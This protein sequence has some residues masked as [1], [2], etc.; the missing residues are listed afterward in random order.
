MIVC[1]AGRADGPRTDGYMIDFFGTARAAAERMG[2]T[3]RI[4]E[5]GYRVE[6]IDY[7]DA[8]GRT[9]ARLG[10]EGFSRLLYRTTIVG[11]SDGRVTVGRRTVGKHYCRVAVSRA[12]LST[13]RAVRGRR[14]QSCS[15]SSVEISR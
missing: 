10:L 7:M 9:R 3:G 13:K 2:I 6:W 14:R 12:T 11:I 4:R 8:S 5:L 15:L 1:G